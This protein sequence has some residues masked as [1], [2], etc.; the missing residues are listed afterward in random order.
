M[1]QSH[2]YVQFEAERAILAGLY[3]MKPSE[4]IIFF[5]KIISV[6]NSFKDLEK[7]NDQSLGLCRL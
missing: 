1:D 3:K 4:R 6:A 5:E 2:D 7:E